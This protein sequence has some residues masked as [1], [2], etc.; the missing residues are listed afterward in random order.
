MLAKT[1]SR[2][3]TGLPTKEPM[4]YKQVKNTILQG[5]EFQENSVLKNASDV[6]FL[7]ALISNYFPS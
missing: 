5:A 7:K 4:K 1:R 3:P 2:S 6:Y